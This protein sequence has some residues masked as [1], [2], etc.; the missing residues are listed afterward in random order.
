[1]RA[2]VPCSRGDG[3]QVSR[4]V[5]VAQR[6]ARV[7]LADRFQVLRDRMHRRRD[8]QLGERLGEPAEALQSPAEYEPRVMISGVQFQHP[9]EGA[10]GTA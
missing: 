5:L 2:K 8:P 7:D 10:F 4:P 6:D 9:G 3:G 1:M